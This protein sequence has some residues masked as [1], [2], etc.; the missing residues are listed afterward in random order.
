MI[1]IVVML[2]FLT[3]VAMGTLLAVGSCS[4]ITSDIMNPLNFALHQEPRV[5]YPPQFVNLWIDKCFSESSCSIPCRLERANSDKLIIFAHGNSSNILTCWPLVCM[6][7]DELHVNVLSFDW[8]GYG[9]NTYSTYERSA[10]GMNATLL[11][12]F[13]FMTG[14]TRIIPDKVFQPSQIVIMG[15][16]VATGPC[17]HVTSELNNIQRLVLLS[18]FSSIL[19]LVRD[20]SK[21]LLG[22]ES[23]AQFTTMFT[24][25]WNNIKAI[26]TLRVPT[27]IIHGKYDQTIPVKHSQKLKQANPEM[28]TLVETEHQHDSILWSELVAIVRE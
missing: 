19:D 10:E 4:R 13:K 23:A 20:K 8:S 1:Y 15:Q 21:G 11:A 9:L 22:H 16:D 3:V 6:L 17:L 24:E 12:V 2:L 26:K 18:P 25:R 28:T 7:R 14:K 5:S 27:L